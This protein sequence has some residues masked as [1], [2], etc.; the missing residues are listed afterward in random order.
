MLEDQGLNLSSMMASPHVKPF[1]EDVRL[2]EQRLSLV[3]ETIEVCSRTHFYLT[4][5]TFLAL[6]I[7][8]VG[9]LA[10]ERLFGNI[11]A[12]VQSASAVS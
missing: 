2:W 7:A 4:Q 10:A 8:R 6:S 3:G 9:T 12:P 5:E 11:Q 1:A